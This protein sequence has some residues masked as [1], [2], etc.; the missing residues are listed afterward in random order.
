MTLKHANVSDNV[1]FTCEAS[2]ASMINYTWTFNG[3]DLMNDPGHIEGARNTTL[4]IISVNVTNGGK[5]SCRANSSGGDFTSDT[6]LLYGKVYHI[7]PLILQCFH[8]HI[9]E[10]RCAIRKGYFMKPQNL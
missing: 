6:A 10:F 2:G 5:Y 9:R 8:I 7:N 4:M 3:S 1:T